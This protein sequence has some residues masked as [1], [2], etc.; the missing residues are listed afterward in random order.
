MGDPT[1]ADAILN[2]VLHHAYGIELKG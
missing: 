2:R 1:L